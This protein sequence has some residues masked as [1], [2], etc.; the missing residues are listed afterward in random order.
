E[1]AIIPLKFATRW[2]SKAGV[3]LEWNLFDPKRATNE[4]EQEL[5]IRQ[6]EIQTAQNARDW[7]R[8]ATLAY[9]SV[10]L[11]TQQYELARQDSAAYADI[12]RVSAAR[13]EAGR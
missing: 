7:Q 9:A 2:L 1:G 11:A 4:K 3:Q 13:Y 5:N 10:V 8:D 6:A 12:L